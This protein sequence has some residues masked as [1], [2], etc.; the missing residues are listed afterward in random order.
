MDPFQEEQISFSDPL[1]EIF[2]SDAE[3]GYPK[4]FYLTD[5]RLKLKR[6]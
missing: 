4:S 1:L 3:I 6:R 2:L 5:I